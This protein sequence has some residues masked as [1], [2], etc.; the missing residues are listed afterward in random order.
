MD[1][2]A[3]S[4]GLLVQEAYQGVGYLL[5][6]VPADSEEEGTR[7]F[8]GC[9]FFG[10]AGGLRLGEGIGHARLSLFIVAE[11]EAG[12]ATSAGLLLEAGNFAP[13][14]TQ[15][16]TSY[17]LVRE[18][19]VISVDRRPS[20]FEQGPRDQGGD[21]QDGKHEQPGHPFGAANAVLQDVDEAPEGEDGYRYYAQQEDDGL[22]AAF[23]GHWVGAI[24]IGDGNLIGDCGLR[25]ANCGLVGH[26][27]L[28]ISYCV[29]RIF[30]V[31]GYESRKES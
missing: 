6:G 23:A 27:E 22:P 20:L 13:G 9:V 14:I 28:L 21:E 5:R 24:V 15:I 3:I 31:E 16:D 17:S 2:E 18:A 29:L 7:L 8:V 4:I 30:G 25:I 1:G 19:V 12:Q 10:R 11:E 26:G